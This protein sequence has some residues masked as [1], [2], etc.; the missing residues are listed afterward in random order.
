[1]AYANAWA[2]REKRQGRE[3]VRGS[4]SALRTPRIRLLHVS[5]VPRVFFEDPPRARC[6]M[7]GSSTLYMLAL[8][9]SKS[10]S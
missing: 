4:V 2:Q 3:M 8:L 7:A 9:S 10:R 5:P 6:A 1:M